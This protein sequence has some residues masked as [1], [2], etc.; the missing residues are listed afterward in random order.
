MRT[1][2]PT[3]LWFLLLGASNLTPRLNGQTPDST[4]RDTSRAV[5]LAPINVTV[6]R[7]V[8]SRAR[9]PAAVGTIDT[10]TLRRGQLLGGLDEALGR[11]PGVIALNRFNPSLDQRLII[12]GA[13]ARGNFGVRGIKILLDGLPQTLPDGQSQL[14]NLDLG[15]VGRAE[16]LLGSSSALYGNGSGGVLSFTTLDPTA[17]WSGRVRV[18]GGS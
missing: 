9:V 8:E 16:A 17:R 14:T 18:T 4:R 6:T 13:G 11:V 15:L 1:P 12:R 2:S 5:E 10:A 7:T 3:L